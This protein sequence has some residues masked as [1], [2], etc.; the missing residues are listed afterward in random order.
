MPDKP[1][2]TVVTPTWN[3][4]KTIVER[5]IPSIWAQTYMPL[6]HI[7][8]TD[9]T[10]EKLN[11][12]LRREGYTESSPV[13][14][15]VNLG[16]NWTS[17]SGNFSIGAAAR[18]VGSYM[19]AGEYISYLDDDDEYRADHV[20]TM[21]AA[22][23]Q[24]YDLVCCPQLVL[25]L[26]EYSSSATVPYVMMPASQI[27]PPRVGTIGGSMFM[28]RASLLRS[29][30]WQLDGYEGDG[31]L[32]ERWIASGCKYKVLDD[33]TVLYHGWNRGKGDDESPVAG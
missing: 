32:V 9:G 14:K 2:V 23:E 29:G 15:L 5:C 11:R 13:R 26:G 7:I 16:R 10:S 27:H 30:S 19:A 21:V 24:G 12:V 6:Q 3:R 1:L 28:H 25:S 22:L 31:K 18:L 4:P 17:Y 8:V 33:P 20:E